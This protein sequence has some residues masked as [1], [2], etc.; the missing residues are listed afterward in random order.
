MLFCYNI[1]NNQRKTRA[2]KSNKIFLKVLY[3]VFLFTFF[4]N[5]FCNTTVKFVDKGKCYN[6]LNGKYLVVRHFSEL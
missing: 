1:T 2:K 3:V 5:I 6:V 4:D